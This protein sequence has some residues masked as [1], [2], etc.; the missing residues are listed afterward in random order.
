MLN[1][2]KLILIITGLLFFTSV[3]SMDWPDWRG[4]NRDGIWKESGIVKKFNG[5]TIPLKWSIPCGPGYSG[6]TVSGGRVYITD[7]PEKSAAS[8]RVL[9]VDAK[10]GNTIWTYSYACQYGNVGYP[11]GPRTSVVINDEKAYSLGTVGNLF[12]FDAKTGTVLWQR[13]LNREY[14]IKMPIWG[15]ASTPLIYENRII[16]PIGG[17]MSASIIALDKNSGKEIWRSMNDKIS[18]SPPVLIQQAGKPVVVVWTAD[19]L[20]GLDP[21][22]GKVYWKIP[23]SV[24]MG[25]GISTP[26]RYGDYLFVSCFYSGSLLV[27]LSRQSITA[28]KIWLRVGESEYKTDALHCVI[29]TPLIKDDCIYGVDSYGELRCLRLLTGDRLW[30]NL[31]AVTK[32]R[33]A[34]IHFI[35][36]GEQTWMFNEHGELLITQLS[37]Q[38]LK[39]L[40]RAK[41]IEPTTGQLNRNGTGVTWSH[42]AFANRHVFARNDNSLIC[43]YLGE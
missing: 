8:E 17:S 7:R 4:N 40:S 20:N 39:I 6:P 16:I 37:P 28:E 2:N 24:K 12:C 34:N 5:K 33:W 36:N 9:C 19:N 11:N 42:P 10:N 30:E 22:T 41:L 21:E 43:A 35:Q 32:N 31:S 25:M 14:Q 15:I 1:L 26:V 13:D 18:Y 38:G 3:S 29:N 23:F 27:K